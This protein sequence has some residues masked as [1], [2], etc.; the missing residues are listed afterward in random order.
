MAAVPNVAA[1]ARRLLAQGF[2]LCK[3]LPMQKRPEGLAWQKKPLAG[4]AVIDDKA[5]GYG[6]LL[7]ANG[8]CSIDPD[9]LEAARAGMARCG[10]DLEELMRAGV[11]TTSTRP[12]SGGRSTFRAPPDLRRVVFAV[13]GQENPTILELRAGQSN[14]Q[15]C[16]PGTTY[17]SKDGKSIYRQAYANGRTIDQA[18]DLPARFLDWWRRMDDD[19][20]FKREQQALLVGASAVLSV[21]GG[22]GAGLTLAFKSPARKDFNKANSVEDILARHAYSN[23][24]GK[25][26]APPTATGAPSV[27]QIPDKV[28]LWQS[29][30]ASDPLCGTFDAWVA[31]VVLDHNGD[32]AAAEEAHSAAV[33]ADFDDLSEPDSALVPAKPVRFQFTPGEDFF[34]PKHPPARHLIKNLLPETGLG[35]LFGPSGSGKSFFAL[36]V[37]MSVSLDREWR[38]R[39]VK[40]GQVAYICAEGGTGFRRRGRA[41]LEYHGLAREGLPLHLLADAPNLLEKGDIKDLIFALRQIK[42]LRLIVVDTLAQTTPGANENTSEDMG[43]V[44]AHC[45]ALVAATGAFV[46]LVGHTGKDEDRGHRG[47]SGMPAAFDVSIQLER[48]GDYRAATVI[49]VKDGQGEGDEFPFHLHSVVLGQDEDG[50]D[51]TSCVALPGNAGGVAGPQ[52]AD[53]KGVWQRVVMQAAVALTDLPGLVTEAQ[54]VA[55]AVNEMPAPDDAKRDRRGRD[56]GRAL[57]SLVKAGR[58]LKAGGFVAVA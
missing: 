6:M 52:R 42:G 35:M 49:K 24:D 33:A 55:A 27:R 50:D 23:E 45:N 2:K 1:E 14:L 34:D 46:L 37:A 11:R 41:Y 19:L 48:S 17:R 18:P 22:E 44:M 54:I 43:R 31:H 4:D 21:S 57:D 40:G 39:R 53:P 38:G 7:A 15:D 16:L 3:L 51:I 30:H 47:W 20:E 36:D 25:R 9:N 5:T 13:R 28:G 12:G 26:W 8:L 58:L 29:D 10:F 56:A 32:Q